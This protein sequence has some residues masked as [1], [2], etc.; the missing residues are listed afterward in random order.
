MVMRAMDASRQKCRDARRKKWPP[1]RKRFE[2][3]SFLRQAV[4]RMS[5]PFFT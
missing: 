2:K 4:R 3:V 1:V 5:E